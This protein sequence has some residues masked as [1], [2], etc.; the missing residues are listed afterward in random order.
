MKFRTWVYILSNKFLPTFFPSPF[1][2]PIVLMLECLVMS[3]T[4]MSLCSLWHYV[5]MVT[6]LHQ[7]LIF[8]TT[9]SFPY[10]FLLF[11]FFF[12]NRTSLLSSSCCP[13]T[14]CSRPGWPQTEIHLL[15]PSACWDLRCILPHLTQLYTFSAIIVVSLLIAWRNHIRHL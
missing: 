13:G 10:S 4:T 2:P 3:D 7:L 14:P 11:I 12:W 9:L 5:N 15:L 1:W 6:H 8:L